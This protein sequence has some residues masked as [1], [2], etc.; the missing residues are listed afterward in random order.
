MKTLLSTILVTLLAAVQVFAQPAPNQNPFGDA[1]ATSSGPT[2]N[3]I[4]TL[5]TDYN[6]I[7]MMVFALIAVGAILYISKVR[8][9]RS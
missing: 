7:L 4:S 5:S 9:V 2:Q 6:S 8:K 1:M 3:S